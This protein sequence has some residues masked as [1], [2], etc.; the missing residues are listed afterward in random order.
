MLACAGGNTF[1]LPICSN[2]WILFKA[3]PSSR[4]EQHLSFT[5]VVV[6]VIVT[7]KYDVA[8]RWV[9]MPLKSRADVPGK[10][11][12]SNHFG[13]KITNEGEL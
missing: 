8:L 5:T 2:A 1:L 11:D 10:L 13:V 4:G 6:G 12:E 3:S 9:S 7:L